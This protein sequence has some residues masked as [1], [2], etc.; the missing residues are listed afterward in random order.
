MQARSAIECTVQLS[1]LARWRFALFSRDA[2]VLS[3]VVATLT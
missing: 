1:L 3:A 2:S